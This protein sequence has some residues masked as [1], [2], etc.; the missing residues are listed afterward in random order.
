[1]AKHELSGLPRLL[2]KKIKYLLFFCLR[3][4]EAPP[5]PLDVIKPAGVDDWGNWGGVEERERQT[6]RDG[7]MMIWG[8]G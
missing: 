4:K 6:V 8:G 1:M 5:P 3:V 7:W 2:K